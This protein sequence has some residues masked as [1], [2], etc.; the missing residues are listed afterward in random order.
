MS[1]EGVVSDEQQ[2][3][4]SEARHNGYTGYPLRMKTAKTGYKPSRSQKLRSRMRLVMAGAKKR[5]LETPRRGPFSSLDRMA[6][7]VGNAGRP[8]L[9]AISGNLLES[10][11]GREWSE[12]S[13]ER[14]MGLGGLGWKV[15]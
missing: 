11:P 7:A 8:G 15:S 6:C 4:L 9:W 14:R 3:K 13:G 10:T 1:S 2:M 5:K 12:V